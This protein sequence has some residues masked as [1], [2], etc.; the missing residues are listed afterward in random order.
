MGYNDASS[1]LRTALD[2]FTT[3][4]LEHPQPVTEAVELWQHIRATRPDQPDRYALRDA[5]I[6]GADE[7]ELGGV[8]LAELGAQHIRNAWN[9][10]EQMIAKHALDLIVTHR[11]DY[12]APLAV[13]AGELIGKLEAIA[14]IGRVPLDALVRAGR[15]TDAE[16]VASLSNVA[17]DLDS[18]YRVRDVY[19]VA[20]G[21]KRLKVGQFDCSRWA[22]PTDIEGAVGGGL[23]LGASFV[24]GITAGGKLWFPDDTAAREAAQKLWDDYEAEAIEQ[25]KRQFGIGSTVY[26]G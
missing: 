26:L 17:A 20:G 23:D 21:Y 1:D 22:N 2:A 6:A 24:A 5:V 25:Q 13:Q 8:L 3:R 15:H 4:G 9:Q 12:H 14:A 7:S 10:A 11:A 19:L 18:A 16:L